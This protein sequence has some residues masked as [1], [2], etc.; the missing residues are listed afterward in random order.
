MAQLSEWELSLLRDGHPHRA[1]L[2]MSVLQPAI[3]LDARVDG[4]YDRGARSIDYGGGRLGAVLFARVTAGMPLWVGSSSGEHDAGIVRVKSIAGDGATGTLSLAENNVVWVHADY[5]RIYE[6]HPLFPV[7]PFISDADPPVFYKDY[8]VA[9]LNDENLE[10]PPVAIAGPPIVVF[11]SGASVRVYIDA[12]ESYAVAPGAVIDTWAWACTGGSIDDATAE[13]TYIDFATA[14]QYWL[15]LTVTDDNV[16]SQITYR[17]VF[18]HS[19]TYGDTNYPYMDFTIKS[20]S[21]SWQSGGWRARLEVRGDATLADIP[22]KTMVVLWQ[23]AYYE[24]VERDVGGW[25]VGSADYRHVLFVGYIVGETIRRDWFAGTVEFEVVQI[26]DFLRNVPMFSISLEYR[27]A[28]TKWYQYANLTVARAVHH[29]WRYHS[30]LFHMCDVMLPMS[31]TWLMYACEDFVYG[32]M[33]GQVDE[34]ANMHGIFAHVCSNKMGQVHVERNVNTL[35]DTDRDAV[36]TVMDITKQD[37]QGAPDIVILR[38]E[39]PR[40]SLIALSGIAYDGA[41][42]TPLISNAPGKVIPHD[43][44]SGV[45]TYDRLVLNNQNQSNELAGRMLAIANNQLREFRI[46]FAGHYLGVV[47]LVP[48]EWYTLSLLASDTK[49]GL[50]FTDKKLLCRDITAKY[51]AESM[52]M[53][54]SGAFEQEAIGDDGVTGDYPV[55]PPP[56]VYPDP[57]YPTFPPVDPVLPDPTGLGR[58]YVMTGDYVT[59]TTL[60]GRTRNFDKPGGAEWVNITG[61]LVGEGCDFILDPWDPANAAYAFTWGGPGSTTTGIWKTENLNDNPPVWTLLRSLSQME[62]DSPGINAVCRFPK[63]LASINWENYIA[64]IYPISTDAG[65]SNGYLGC[66]HSHNRG[67]DWT[68]ATIVDQSGASNWRGAADLVP[69]VING[70]LMLYACACPQVGLADRTRIYRSTDHGASW[71]YFFEIGA[72]YVSGAPYEH[73][74]TCPYNDNADGNRYYVIASKLNNGDPH[75]RL[76]R[77][78]GASQVT[79]T[80]A[81][82]TFGIPAFHRIGVESHT[83]DWQLLYCYD[84]QAQVPAGPNYKLHVS[85]DA[86]DSW[87][88]KGLTSAKGIG[89]DVYA[90]GGFPYNTQL[91]Y[92]LGSNG[93]FYSLDGGDTFNDATGDWATEVGAWADG[94]VVVPVWTE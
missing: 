61:A 86:G 90:A 21:G 87:T 48:Q 33:Y 38:D 1:R 16:R 37:R 92:T 2:Y 52:V 74:L 46:D 34:F 22:D 24:G 15:S 89:V 27:A 67:I 62:G 44:G 53:I 70:E 82:S 57:P 59:K 13:S 8:D 14:G 72:A 19:T 11:L 73:T 41:D 91:F 71:V 6:D 58:V 51:S 35:G 26:T 88:D 93:I 31:N 29:L 20:F 9:Y 76:R 68:Y 10:P 69:H 81:P 25:T 17:P 4:A 5:L 94:R 30:T 55:D 79:R 12:S 36:T 80:P 23:S 3:L 65:A 45:L 32:N 77:C 66:W 49:R 85:D 39:A 28:P 47:D 40:T 60:L 54:T 64:V 7:F 18:V 83:F 75:H 56:I 42:E 78:Y 43:E 50:S 63:L 84:R